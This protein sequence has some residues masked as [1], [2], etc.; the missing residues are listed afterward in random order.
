VKALGAATGSSRTDA[1]TELARFV[2]TNPAVMLNQGLR[3]LATARNL[4]I[5][6][7]ARLF[8]MTST[9][10]SDALI[11]CWE[12][13]EYW[14]F[15]RPI[16]AIR[17]ADTD[18]N[19]ATEKQEDWLP[20][21]NTPPYPDHPSGYNC[22]TAGMMYAARAF[23]GTDRVAFSLSSPVT[24]ATRQYTRLT[25]VVDDTIDG[26]IYTGFH[27]RTSDVQ[28]AWIGKKVAQWVARHEFGPAD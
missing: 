4:S 13:K 9:S 22:V 6:E 7:A 10:A 17:L 23:V 18:G 27:F 8:A 25:D 21:F 16:T 3:G 12:D 11:A 15:W 19:R 2:T 20:F 14:S 5:A 26:R 1:Q 24:G 28:G